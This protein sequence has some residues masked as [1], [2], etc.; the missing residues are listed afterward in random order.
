MRDMK[1]IAV[2]P[3]SSAAETP[4]D[5]EVSD[6]V[7]ARGV[8]LKFP[9]FQQIAVI[10]SCTKEER[11]ETNKNEKKRRKTKAMRKETKIKDGSNAK[12]LFQPPLHQPHKENF[13]TAAAIADFLVGLDHLPDWDGGASQGVS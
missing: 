13:P 4:L 6:R 7:S 2:G 5:R 3:L 10:C 1:S 8:R 11:R 9:V 12:I